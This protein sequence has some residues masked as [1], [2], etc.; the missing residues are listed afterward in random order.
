MLKKWQGEVILVVSGV[1]S[2]L[3]LLW[4]Q[5]VPSTFAA[6]ILIGFLVG[7]YS[8]MI[9]FYNNFPARRMSPL[10]DGY[11]FMGSLILTLVVAWGLN[12]FL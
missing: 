3:L 2:A 8:F 1:V 4:Q 9:W 10:K 12:N 7:G 11:I 5:F 6:V